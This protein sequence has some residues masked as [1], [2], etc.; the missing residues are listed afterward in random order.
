M[1]PAG[2]RSAAINHL[3]RRRLLPERR[4]LSQVILGS[5]RPII[6]QEAPAKDGSLLSC[7]PEDDEC[8]KS[9]KNITS[10][11][12]TRGANFTIDGDVQLL[13][14]IEACLRPRLAN[15]AKLSAS[16]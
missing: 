7:H 13:P 2:A 9:E 14:L 6:L 5:Q 4:R 16:Y 3:T 1:R 12:Q 15:L 8:S 10:K 11:F